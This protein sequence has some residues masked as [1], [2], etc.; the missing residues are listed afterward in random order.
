VVP[1]SSLDP[2]VD[3]MRRLRSTWPADDDPRGIFLEAYTLMTWRMVEA[4]EA[5][6]FGDA[7]WVRRLLD[8]F[9][10]YYF[11]AVEA[12]ER[13]DPATPQAWRLALEAAGR[14]EV[15]VLQHLLLGINAHITYDLVFTIAELLDPEWDRLDP[16]GR[17]ARW[18]D[19]RRVDEIIAATIDEVQ[20]TVVAARSPWLG[21]VDRAL[22]PVDERVF[23]AVIASWRCDVWDHAIAFVSAPP[24]QRAA[25]AAEVEERAVSRSRLLLHLG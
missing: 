24:A 22:G 3:R 12:F 4:I 10:D 8:R 6:R 9:A 25:I 15:G 14:P 16:S 13:D 20:S 5:G 11:H 17:S 7:V 1:E 19:H 18:D 2:V 21:V 23:G